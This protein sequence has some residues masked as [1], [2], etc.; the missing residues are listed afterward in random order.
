MEFLLNLRQA[1]KL[2]HKQKKI[3]PK[4]LYTYAQC[5]IN[6]YDSTVE[7]GLIIKKF[8]LL[9]K[10]FRKKTQAKRLVFME[11]YASKHV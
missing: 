8:E 9:L 3:Y 10:H 4:T 11:T 2:I 6:F 5:A 1:N 7:H